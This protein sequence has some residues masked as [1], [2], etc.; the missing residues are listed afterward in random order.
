MSTPDPATTNWVPLWP[1]GDADKVPA[2]VIDAAGDLIVGSG[3]DAVT[4][5]GKGSVGQVLGIDSGGN[6]AYITPPAPAGS[7]A[8]IVDTELVAAA[9]TIDLTSIPQTFK[10]LCVYLQ[11]RNTSTNGFS[12]M[13][14]NGDAVAA[15]YAGSPAPST[16]G[17][18][19]AQVGATSASPANSYGTQILEL[20]YYS[21]SPSYKQLIGR[22]VDAGGASGGVQAL[23]VWKQTAAITRLTIAPGAN[24]FAAGSR[25]ILYGI[26]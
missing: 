1:L 20:P 2:S 24:Q 5:L 6:V 15:D 25:V 13:Q 3:P 9:S 11:T 23:G 10:H 4:R 14:V 22:A 7:W 12:S 26:T 21:R 17:W 8:Q 18:Q 16:Q 19:L